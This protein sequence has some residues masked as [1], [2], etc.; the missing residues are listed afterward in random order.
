MDLQYTLK[1]QIY[2]QK[3]PFTDTSGKEDPGQKHLQCKK[4]TIDKSLQ[5]HPMWLNERFLHPNQTLCWHKEVK[6][7]LKKNET[8][9]FVN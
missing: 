1:A 9:T 2:I 3:E 7:T 6:K 4:Y 8:S 5:V